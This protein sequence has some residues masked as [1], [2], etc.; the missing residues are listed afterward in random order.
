[1]RLQSRCI[2]LNS[3]SSAILSAGRGVSILFQRGALPPCRFI[4]Y[5][6]HS[7]KFLCVI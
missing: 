7:W 3:H 5:F 2:A 4:H 6:I 1:M